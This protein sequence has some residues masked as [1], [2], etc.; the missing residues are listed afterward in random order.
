MTS[1]STIQAQLPEA[2][3][4]VRRS[5]NLSTS[6]EFRKPRN[7]Q[8]TITRLQSGNSKQQ[9]RDVS[10][11][12][13]PGAFNP[14]STMN[15]ILL[16][17]WKAIAIQDRYK[18]A[19]RN[20][21]KWNN[22][23]IAVISAPFQIGDT[24]VV[25]VVWMPGNSA[26]LG[27]GPVGETKFESFIRLAGFVWEQLSCLDSAGF[28]SPKYWHFES[29][30]WS[31]TCIVSQPHWCRLKCWKPL[32]WKPSFMN[33]IPNHTQG[34]WNTTI[35]VQICKHIAGRMLYIGLAKITSLERRA[36]HV[37]AAAVLGSQHCASLLPRTA[38]RNPVGVR[39]KGN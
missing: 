23:I 21:E 2:E 12:I 10:T 4:K 28:A 8:S 16:Q 27:F 3:L 29:E 31:R 34:N 14:N 39:K 26:G 35:Q 5:L 7:I 33:K 19:K 9:L 32:P 6:F 20:L 37:R 30:P 11:T 1:K 13:N 15:T 25:G 24:Q 17:L 18:H 22:D 38:P 36:L